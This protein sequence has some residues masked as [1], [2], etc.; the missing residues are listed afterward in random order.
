MARTTAKHFAKRIIKAS[1]KKK[2]K[3]AP[4]KKVMHKVEIK[5]PVEEENHTTFLQNKVSGL[6][7]ELRISEKLRQAEISNNTQKIE[8]LYSELDHLRQRVYG[9]KSTRQKRVEELERKIKARTN[10]ELQKVLEMEQQLKRMQAKYEELK[11]KKKYPASSLSVTEMA[12]RS[13]KR[14]IDEKKKEIVSAPEPSVRHIMRFEAPA[15]KK[16]V[17]A[18]EIKPELPSLPPLVEKPGKP[19]EE[20]KIPQVPAE[21]VK[22]PKRTFGQKIRIVL[23]GKP[24]SKKFI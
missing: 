14:R 12:I 18:E 4:P 9:V 17:P 8:G 16:S 7:Q 23:F 3:H 15:P 19:I 22:R 6:E 5:P 21:L 1:K 20:M 2:V 24:K 13:L 10:I 11:Q